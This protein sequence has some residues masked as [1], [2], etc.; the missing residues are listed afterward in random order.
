ME[1]FYTSYPINQ[2]LKFKPIA[3]FHE[4]VEFSRFY[5][6]PFNMLSIVLRSE[7]E[8]AS[9]I[10]NLKTG[11]VR[12]SCENQIAMVPC[13]LP[14]FYQHTLRNERLNIHFQLE[15][16]PGVDVFSGCDHCMM[17]VS[18]E[19]RQKAWEIFQIQDPILRLSC[20]TSFALNFCHRHWPKE[21]PVNFEK[22]NRYKELLE[23]ISKHI[24]AETRGA[25]I[26]KMAGLSQRSF[27]REFHELFKMSPKAYLQRELLSRAATCL[28][29]PRESVKSIAEKLGFANEFYFSRFFRKMSGMPP[30]HYQKMTT[31][32]SLMP[33]EIFPIQE[34]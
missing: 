14:Q 4:S 1:K 9:V 25:N 19:L 18:P 22:V 10:T 20:C 16:F 7:G 26:A 34:K 23:K 5:Q 24:S 13:N 29:N 12:E 32:Y 3:I 15:L 21:Y 33:E 27:D 8:K 11:E 2:T 28:A 30:S 17:E 31:Q 6:L